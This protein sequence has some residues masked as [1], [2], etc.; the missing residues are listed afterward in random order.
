MNIGAKELDEVISYI[1]KYEHE[2]EYNT[3]LSG[4]KELVD[5]IKNRIKNNNFD[6]L[7]VNLLKDDN[8]IYLFNNEEL[9][10]KELIVRYE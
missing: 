3:I 10:I 8:N 5:K 2:H 7:Y 9:N 6:I 1:N 4:N